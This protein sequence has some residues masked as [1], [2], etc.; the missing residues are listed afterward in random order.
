MTKIED[1]GLTSKQIKEL[2]GDTVHDNFMEWMTGQIM[3]VIDG[4]EVYY[5]NDIKRFSSN[6]VLKNESI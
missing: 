1:Y 4:K 5:Y 6:G 3:A 2:F